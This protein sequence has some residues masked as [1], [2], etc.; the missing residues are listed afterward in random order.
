MLKSAGA[1]SRR[2][3]PGHSSLHPPSPVPLIER[4]GTS[5]PGTQVRTWVNCMPL[6]LPGARSFRLT[7]KRQF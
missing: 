2:L 5:R 6:E 3:A 4:C 1:Q 7:F